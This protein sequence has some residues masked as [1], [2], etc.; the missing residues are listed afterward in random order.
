M[1]KPS[2]FLAGKH[3]STTELPAGKIGFP[4]TTFPQIPAEFLWT[5]TKQQNSTRM[6]ILIAKYSSALHLN[7]S[8]R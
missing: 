5:L 2:G 7:P 1:G 6:I 8:R 3:G 4:S